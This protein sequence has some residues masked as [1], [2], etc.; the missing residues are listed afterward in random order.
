MKR[1]DKRVK[2]LSKEF[3]VPDSYHERVDKLLTELQKEE[4]SVQP[5]GK[6]TGFRVACVAGVLCI[7]LISSFVF[8]GREERCL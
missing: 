2:N 4:Y 7:L 6:K 1:C 8:S 3:P 5:P